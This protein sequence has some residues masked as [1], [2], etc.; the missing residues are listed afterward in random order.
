MR[1]DRLRLVLVHHAAQ[2]SSAAE[3]L[4]H[5][6]LRDLANVPDPQRARGILSEGIYVL[7]LVL[8]DP[9]YGPPFEQVWRDVRE[10]L[11]ARKRSLLAAR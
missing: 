9:Q 10:E 4:L 7:T 1:E 11:E 6:V 3:D 8:N 5:E 2:N